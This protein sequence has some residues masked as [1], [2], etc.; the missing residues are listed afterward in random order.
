MDLSIVIP[1]FNTRKLL[2]ECLQSIEKNE[3]DLKLEI[4]VVDNGSNDGSSEMVENDF[5]RVKL[6]KNETNLG[7]AKG[8][9]QGIKKAKGSHVLVLNSDIVVKPK[10]LK[11]LWQFAKKTPSAGVVGGRLLNPDGS[12]QGS[13][14]FLPTIWRTF[15]A[16]WLGK[17]KY[18]EKFAPKGNR[19][20]EV[21]A[22]IG[23]AFLITP[24]AIQ[25]VGLF[26]EKYFIYFEDLDYC[27]RAR[28]LGFKVYY[29]PQTEFIHYHGA[30]GKEMPTQRWLQASSR[31]Y[32]GWLRHY[33]IQLIIKAGRKWRKS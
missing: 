25:K 29:L 26:D 30:S 2:K 15:Q 24:R 17:K 16:Y 1:S 28:K 21:E 6:I 23:A 12:V 5:S 32:H 13:C 10:S 4:I 20:E 33:L 8:V 31:K 27:R 19:P 3:E 18:R 14:Y 7:F 22:V 9:N 11:Q